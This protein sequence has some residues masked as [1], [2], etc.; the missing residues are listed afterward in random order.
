MKE[1]TGTLWA[2]LSRRRSSSE[3]KDVRGER[4]LVL[5]AAALPLPPPSDGSAW[6]MRLLKHTPLSQR[7][8]ETP[9][10][11]PATGTPPP[12]PPWTTLPTCTMEE[13]RWWQT[14]PSSQGDVYIHATQANQSGALRQVDTRVRLH[15]TDGIHDN[16]SEKH[17]ASLG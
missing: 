14:S 4:P 17:V 15:Q 16:N 3:A 12:H 8:P 13:R 6:R 7:D 2:R 1:R 11:Q 10:P 9:A 5:G